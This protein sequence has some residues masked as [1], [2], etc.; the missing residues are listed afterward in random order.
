MSSVF[1]ITGSACFA[2]VPNV[3]RISASI[4]LAVAAVC[5]QLRLLC[6]MLDG[7]MAVE[8]GKRTKCGEIYNE[9]P[10][11]V[12][13]VALLVGAGYAA[14]S[15]FGP[16]LGCASAMLALATAYI[17]AF[18][19]RFGKSQDFSGPMAKQHRMF[20]LTVGSLLTS[21]SLCLAH[22]PSAPWLVAKVTPLFLSL[23]IIF[24]GSIITCVRRTR[25]LIEVLENEPC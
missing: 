8:C 22:F 10:D 23:E 7:M 11:R 1:A 14:E 20:V 19:S 25:N 18:G 24:V 12:S 17:R 2:A 4:L 3:S 21:G 16:A 13:D 9:F 15:T 5:I 6:N